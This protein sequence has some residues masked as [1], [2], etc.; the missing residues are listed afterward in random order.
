M[1][2]VYHL[3]Y[4]S[5]APDSLNYSDLLDILKVARDFNEKNQISGVLIYRDGFF[6]QLLEGD[7]NKID[8]LMKNIKKDPRNHSIRILIESE[9]SGR[10]FGDWSMAFIDGD[11]SVN[12]TSDLINL[13]ELATQFNHSQKELIMPVLKKFR[14]SLPTVSAN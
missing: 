6:I 12:E 13:F 9:S 3:L 7:K 1:S 5:E 4:V 10:I 11:L 2:E 14:Q 8:Q